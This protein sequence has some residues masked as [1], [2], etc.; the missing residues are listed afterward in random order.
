MVNHGSYPAGMNA[1]IQYGQRI[2]GLIGYL[3]IY[4]YL[5]CKRICDLCIHMFGLPL[6]QGSVDNIL[7]ELILKSESVYQ[8]L[9]TRI[10]SSEVVGADETGCR[11]NGRK[12]WFH[13]WQDRFITFIVAFASRGHKVEVDGVLSRRI[14]TL[15]LCE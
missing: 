7:E 8:K 15:L 4:Q 5:P 1:P 14:H 6:S 2:K 13:V 9:R 11:V 10:D 12:H 3:S